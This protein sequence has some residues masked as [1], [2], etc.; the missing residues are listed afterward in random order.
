MKK[1]LRNY[2]NTIKSFH[3]PGHKNGKLQL[4]NDFYQLDVTE[5]NGTDDM[6]HPEDMIKKALEEISG[7][8]GSYKSYML[9]NGSTSGILSAIGGTTKR[10]DHII[11]ARNCH[12]SVYNGAMLG[13]LQ[14][15]YLYQTNIVDDESTLNYLEDNFST[16]ENDNSI[17]SKTGVRGSI[18]KKELED[19]LQ[20]GVKAVVITS[21]T[22]EGI[23]SDIKEI[24]QLVHSY[25]AVLIVDEAHGAHLTFSGQLPK[26]A[27]ELGADIVIQSTHKT[28][29][30]LT[31]TGLLHVS[32]EAVNSQ[33]VDLYKL[34]RQLQIYQSSSPSY[35]FMNSIYESVLYMDSHRDEFDRF[36]KE[37][38]DAKHWFNSV[39]KKVKLLM[40][41]AVDGLR[42]TFMLD[43]NCLLSGYDLNQRL[44][45][46]AFIQVELSGPKHIVAIVTVAD[47][48]PEVRELMEAVLLMVDGEDT[49][50]EVDSYE[51]VKHSCEDDGGKDTW[52]KVSLDKEIIEPEIVI[53]MGEAV[54][55]EAYSVGLDEASGCICGDFVI[56]YPP[57]IPLI[58]P[59]ERFSAGVIKKIEDY[60]NVSQEVYGVK[61]DINCGIIKREVKV[62]RG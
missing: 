47:S 55:R 2:T 39:G 14:V 26:S 22:Y 16:D 34:E 43:E 29:P 49:C 15:S 12:R 59:G 40:G 19:K 51:G 30:A 48:V 25:G 31:Q 57:G 11:I 17:A 38:M 21:P 9:V 28:L 18:V 53:P 13:G 32:E 33:R 4:V 46:E 5:V 7:I 24:A 8:Y 41:S 3:M 50:D 20:D 10:G 36:V 27:F 54:E 45:E 52:N 1:E 37:I 42:L 62:L 58:V 56:P 23:V 44:R 60:V 61:E 35:V 6:H